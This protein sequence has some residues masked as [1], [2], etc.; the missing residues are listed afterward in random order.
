MC[1]C[2]AVSTYTNNCCVYAGTYT[3]NWQRP[4]LRPST[5]GAGR[6]AP[7]PRRPGALNALLPLDISIREIRVLSI[8]LRYHE[9]SKHM[10]VAGYRLYRALWQELF[11]GSLHDSPRPPET[12]SR[13]TVV[14]GVCV[15]RVSKID[16]GYALTVVT[17]KLRCVPGKGVIWFS[18]L[19]LNVW[20]QT[21]INGYVYPSV[22]LW[23]QSKF[24][25]RQE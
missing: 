3:N 13:H 20:R 11:G 25:F 15:V 16:S 2:P 24:P 1:V 8:C 23:R 12:R 7:R 6:D 14:Q 10:P 22:N 17:I 5:S 9:G 19:S 18:W 4:A 21:K